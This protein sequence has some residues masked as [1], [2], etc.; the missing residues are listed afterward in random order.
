MRAYVLDSLD[1]APRAVEAP[2][3]EIGAGDVLVRVLASSVNPHDAHVISGAAQAYM[4]YRFPITLGNDLAGVV[5]EVGADV[6]R[7]Q[8]GDKV[9]GVLRETV[10]HRGT[11]ADYVAVP[12]DEF[13]V[14]QP[15]GLDDVEAGTLGLASVA[16]MASLEPLEVGKGDTVLINGATGGVGSC[17]IQIAS[18]TGARV[19]ATARPGDEERHVRELGAAE[20][21]D[22]SG[23][24]VAVAVRGRHPDGIDGLVD[25]VNYDPTA[26]A[27]LATAV[28]RPGGRAASTLQA[29]DPDRLPDLTGT[30]VIAMAK[31]VF[32]AAMADMAA[33]GTLR[34]TVSQVHDFDHIDA[35]LAALAEGT[36][37]KIALRFAA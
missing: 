32:L 18:A 9:F 10:A 25:L 1:A 16:A 31:P 24:D 12:A 20:V 14:G 35:A 13:L 26:F 28:L 19:I 7:F 11:F 2:R 34:A 21:V 33:S 36:L 15:A 8:P 22:W 6:R 3:P 4:E 29:A 27:A 30:N 17:A 23:G 37:G 5:E